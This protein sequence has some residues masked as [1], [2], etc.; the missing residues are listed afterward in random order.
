MPADNFTSRLTAFEEITGYR[1]DGPDVWI[2]WLGTKPESNTL[3]GI[4]NH[5]LQ[6]VLEG[7]ALYIMGIPLNW[8]PEALKELFV[9]LGEATCCPCII[10]LRSG[11]VFRWVIMKTAAQATLAMRIINNLP[12]GGEGRVSPHLYRAAPPG[13]TI[14]F[15]EEFPLSAFR[16][17]ELLPPWLH[18]PPSDEPTESVEPAA[19]AEPAA[20]EPARHGTTTIVPAL[21]LQP[22]A[23]VVQPPTPPT[24][25]ARPAPSHEA[26]AVTVVVQPPTPPTVHAHPA[27]LDGA[28]GAAGVVRPAIPAIY[29]RPAPPAGAARGA[30]GVVQPPTHPVVHARPALPTE[31]RGDTGVVQPPT[32]PAVHARPAPGTE[33]PGAAR[34]LQRPT[35]PALHLRPAP[36][37]ARQPSQAELEQYHRINQL[38]D[39]DEFVPQAVTWANIVSARS[40]LEP[41]REGPRPAPRQASGN[42][43]RLNSIGRIPPV[44]RQNRAGVESAAAKMRVVFLLNL[45]EHVTLINVSDAIKEG[46]LVSTG[47][48][49]TALCC[50][51]E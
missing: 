24:D 17:W 15:S 37:P 51:V 35:F 2:S 8:H 19:P 14:T 39:L 30:A 22:I 44:V 49:N 48:F 46:S 47:G 20:P 23:V 3:P 33:A 42:G 13:V 11:S 32:L 29:A 12:P 5:Y 25:H 18:T 10:D 28:H 7:R 26:S 43:P 16:N 27:P 50:F 41:E 36:Q 31:A 6:E 38:V 40:G 4:P 9:P 34:V 45:P 21:P 1:A